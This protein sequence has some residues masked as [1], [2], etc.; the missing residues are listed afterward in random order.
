[1]KKISSLNKYKT[2]SHVGVGCGTDTGWATYK[3]WVALCCD[4]AVHEV[5]FCL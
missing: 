5:G 3:Y 4:C 2:L 1:M